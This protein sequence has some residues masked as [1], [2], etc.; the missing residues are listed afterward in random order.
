MLAHSDEYL[1]SVGDHPLN[2]GATLLGLNASYMLSGETKYSEWVLKYIDVLRRKID[3]LNDHKKT[4][5]G[6]AMLPQMYGDPHGYR[7]RG[8]PEVGAYPQ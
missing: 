6:Q 7:S 4:V 5:A 2:M 3:I 1:D 8:E